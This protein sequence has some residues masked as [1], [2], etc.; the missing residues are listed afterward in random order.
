MFGVPPEKAFLYELTGATKAGV[1]V[2][3]ME[4]ASN[5]V[6]LIDGLIW[7][8]NN[9]CLEEGYN[10][11]CFGRPFDPLDIC[12]ICTDWLWTLWHRKPQGCALLCSQ[13]EKGVVNWWMPVGGTPIPRGFRHSLRDWGS[14]DGWPQHA[15]VLGNH[16]CQWFCHFWAGYFEVKY[17]R[18]CRDVFRM[19]EGFSIEFSK[20]M[21]GQYNWMHLQRAFALVVFPFHFFLQLNKPGT[22]SD[23]SICHGVI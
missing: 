20:K 18:R 8:P 10:C 21:I 12:T 11:K 23:S 9:W 14:W 2:Q 6:S 7:V 17:P 19:F 13:L 5:S 3:K 4:Q 15:R 1:D 22:R 16:V